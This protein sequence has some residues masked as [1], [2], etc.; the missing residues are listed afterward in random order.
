MQLM[1]QSET[2]ANRLEVALLVIK[3]ADDTGYTSN[4]LNSEIKIIKPGASA[5]NATNGSTH[6]SNGLHRFI[7]T[8]SEVDTVGVLKIQINQAS[9][10]G[11]VKEVQ[12]VAFDP[13]S[14][15]SLGLTNLDTTVSSRLATSSYEDT[16]DFL[17]KTNAIETG[18]TPRGALRLMLAVLLGKVSG[19]GTGTENF[20][21]AVADTKTRVTAVVDT[22]GNRTTITTD[23]T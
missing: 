10:Y 19:A 15:A 1:K 17:D 20:R 5:V 16:D 8:Q 12:V 3:T 7:L 18:V 22:S 11:D 21:N 23:Q 2:T 14:Q 13:Y 6:L 4:L 9:C